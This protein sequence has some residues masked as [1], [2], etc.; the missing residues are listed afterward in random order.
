MKRHWRNPLD[1]RD[2]QV[3]PNFQ[4]LGTNQSFVR[5]GIPSQQSVSKSRPPPPCPVT[6]SAEVQ[7][8][9]NYQIPQWVN[10]KIEMASTSNNVERASSIPIPQG[11][12]PPHGYGPYSGSRLH[13]M[14]HVQYSWT[15]QPGTPHVPQSFWPLNESAPLGPPVFS[16]DRSHVHPGQL[17]SQQNP[18]DRT[19]PRQLQQEHIL[20]QYT[21]PAPF[22]PFF[23]DPTTG[24]AL[25]AGRPIPPFGILP[26]LQPLPG[27]FAMLT[28]GAMPVIMMP[29]ACPA[30]ALSPPQQ[31]LQPPQT[32]NATPSAKALIAQ[33][34]PKTKSQ[35]I[36]Q[37][38]EQQ[39]LLSL[40]PR[41]CDGQPTQASQAIV[42]GDFAET[43]DGLSSSE[44]AKNRRI[45]Q[46][47]SEQTVN[48]SPTS[49]D[50]TGKLQSHMQ[51][52]AHIQK[53][54]S[55]SEARH[56]ADQWM[57]SYSASDIAHYQ[58]PHQPIYLPRFIDWAHAST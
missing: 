39:R 28:S 38:K 13:N 32:P 47:K 40:K 21:P 54:Q 53:P 26:A 17:P 48:R 24:I 57:P 5:R 50:H 3:N 19:P 8:N 29:R 45:V 20:S 1:T 31:S 49:S 58:Q 25:Q 35:G 44:G 42:F 7:R 22:I 10:S 30:P 52:A 55:L 41:L 27:D 34:S 36:R 56:A 51:A 37:R 2:P 15:N 4:A 16:L 6:T 9:D 18:I 43:K 11:D 23:V 33:S 12:P 14:K 46:D